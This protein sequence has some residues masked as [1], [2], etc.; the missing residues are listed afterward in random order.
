MI[1][2]YLKQEGITVTSAVKK[3]ELFATVEV[4]TRREFERVI[5]FPPACWLGATAARHPPLTIR[6]RRVTLTP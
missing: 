6:S 3:E 1:V 2:S 4:A 5:G